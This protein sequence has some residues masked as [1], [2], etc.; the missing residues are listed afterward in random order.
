MNRYPA[1]KYAIIALAFAVG[2]LYAVP[3]IFG[4]VPAVQVSPIKATLKVDAALMTRVDQALVG[5][6]IE[7]KGGFMD[8][9]SI[10][11][12][13]ADPDTQI[14]AKDVLQRAL[15]DDYVVALN[16]LPNAPRWMISRYAHA[17]QGSQSLARD[18]RQA[19]A[20]ARA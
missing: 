8:P 11:V 17:L 9:T 1:W 13:F 18:R 19:D 15:G 12:R 10:K 20:G 14:K 16:L 4:E 3:N 6:G 7:S 5:A 2:I